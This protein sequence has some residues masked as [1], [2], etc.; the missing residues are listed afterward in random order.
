MKTIIIKGSY[1]K[2]GITTS[3]VESFVKGLKEKNPEM[4]IKIFDLLDENIEFC[5]GCG[6]CAKDNGLKLGECITDDNVKNILQEMLS[7]DRIVFAS[8]IYEG[9]MTALF[10]RFNEKVPN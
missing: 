9:C 5:K 6:N 8:P 10:K 7:C 4:K 2:N 1:H 3:L